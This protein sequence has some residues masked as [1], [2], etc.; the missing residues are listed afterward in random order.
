MVKITDLAA[1]MLGR[2]IHPIDAG[3]VEAEIIP[4]GSTRAT[5]AF[6]TSWDLPQ[7]TEVLPEYEFIKAAIE[8][9]DPQ[10][11][12]VTGEAGTGK[13]TLIHWLVKNL[14][15]CA[16][17]APTAIAASNIHGSTLH[18]FFGLPP[19][20]IDIDD[21]LSAPAKNRVVMENMT[22]LVI[23]EISM[24]PPNLIDVIDHMLRKIR[25][26]ELPFGGVHVVMVGDLYQLPPVV[27]G[28]ELEVY[29]THRYK[30]P[31]FFSADV[32]KEKGAEFIPLVLSRVRRQ[33][34]EGL[35]KALSA[36]RSGIDFR[37]SLG[38]FNRT[39]YRDRDSALASELNL[40]PTNRQATNINTARL[41]SIPG[42]EWVFDAEVTGNI[43]AD[44][45]KLLVPSKLRL[46]IGA[47][48]IF[49]NNQAEWING[50]LGEVVGFGDSAIRVRK[51]STD[52]VVSVPLHSWQKYEY[53][54]SYE[55]KRITQSSVASFQQYPLNLGWAM[56]IH[57]SQGMT[58]DS[59]SIDLGTG[60]F[61]E[62]QVY[63]ALSRAKSIE[64]IKLEQPIKM[65]DVKVHPV[66][67]EFYGRLIDI[68]D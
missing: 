61:G 18:S 53:S 8:E 22:C 33:K 3:A 49:L 21:E 44:D 17:V 42:E 5:G 20:H 40:V 35:I 1:R 31:F 38:Y 58:L 50:D 48:V 28:K 15:E 13:S 67:Q 68:G 41:N 6:T 43:Q 65:T 14:G 26:P 10:P 23:D 57:K 7:G 55:E 46:K 59:Y 29:F 39:C 36:I 66:V 30:S 60:A 51:L 12:F 64:S 11:I 37:E 62:G 52:N 27:K 4:E 47:K 32:F 2:T 16:L 45:W 25:D 56:T 19:R 9:G 63:V 24:V 34:D 54:Y